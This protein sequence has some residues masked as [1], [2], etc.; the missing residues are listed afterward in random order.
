MLPFRE[1]SHPNRQQFFLDIHTKV[2]TWLEMIALM[3]V[4]LSVEGNISR[5]LF[6]L[7]VDENISITYSNVYFFNVCCD[8]IVINFRRKIREHFNFTP[9][10]FNINAYNFALTETLYIFLFEIFYF[11]FSDS[12]SSIISIK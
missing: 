3:S 6:A 8:R 5:A 9:Y 7:S 10:E 4:N 12:I 11:L 2:S 1:V